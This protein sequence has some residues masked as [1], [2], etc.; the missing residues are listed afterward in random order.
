VENWKKRMTTTAE[1]PVSL[2]AADAVIRKYGA[3]KS[4]L[5]MIIQDVQEAYNW[6]P[7][8]VLW[9][10]AE[11]LGLPPSHVYNVAT[12]YASFSLK[13]R[14]K[15]VIRLCD[16]TACHLRGSVWLRDE[17]SRVVGIQEGQ[18]TPDGTFTFETVACLGACALAPVMAIGRKY[19]GQMTPEK[20][21]ETLKHYAKAASP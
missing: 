2:K 14:G 18:T 17:I 21:K 8:P 7:E 10:I 1:K 20:V 15:H 4:W 12:F 5:V 6:L 11:R 3:E 13:A 9:H 19:Y 16:G